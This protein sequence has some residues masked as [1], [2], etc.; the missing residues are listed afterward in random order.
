MIVTSSGCFW[1]SGGCRPQSQLLEFL[2]RPMEDGCRGMEGDSS[3]F[4]K[5]ICEMACEI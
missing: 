1:N 5:D 2:Q 4:I 3:I